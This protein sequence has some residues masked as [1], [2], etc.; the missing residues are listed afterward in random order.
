MQALD[1][2]R[3]LEMVGQILEDVDAQD[4]ASHAEF[5]NTGPEPPV[6]RDPGRHGVS[7][8]RCGSDSR[9]G[10]ELRLFGGGLLRAEH[11]NDKEVAV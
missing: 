8:R 4:V 10:G 9:T 1:L 2:G 3:G 11:R 7:L 6:R 5:V